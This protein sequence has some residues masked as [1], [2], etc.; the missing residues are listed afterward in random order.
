MTH[1]IQYHTIKK[2]QDQYD[3]VFDDDGSQEIADIVGIKNIKDEQI[4]VD[5]YH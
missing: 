2:I 1:S 3:I 5:F 4:V